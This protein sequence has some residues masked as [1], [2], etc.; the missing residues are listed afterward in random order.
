MRDGGQMP[1]SALTSYAVFMLRGID[2]DDANVNI[3]AAALDFLAKGGEG[4][5]RRGY[6][7][8]VGVRVFRK[9]RDFEG[10]S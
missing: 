4:S 10:R 7:Y 9:N 2:A 6:P 8:S 1:K 3:I 5:E